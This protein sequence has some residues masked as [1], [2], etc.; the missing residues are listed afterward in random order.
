MHDAGGDQQQAWRF[1]ADLRRLRAHR[2]AAVGDQEDMV[3]I[4]VNMR[5]DRP[6]AGAGAII[7]TFDVDEAFADAPLWFAIEIEAGDGG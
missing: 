7:E 5:A 2:A 3:E 4:A 6:F 1:E